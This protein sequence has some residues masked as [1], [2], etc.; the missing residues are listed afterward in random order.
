[1]SERKSITMQGS[2]GYRVE[3]VVTVKPDGSD[4]QM[5]F[6]VTDPHGWDVPLNPWNPRHSKAITTLE[7]LKFVIAREG[8]DYASLEEI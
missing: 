1:M 5:Y 7:E 6:R 4:P 2:K 3:T 8:E